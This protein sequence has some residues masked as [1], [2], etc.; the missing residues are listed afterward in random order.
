M[1]NFSHTQIFRV[2]IFELQN[3]CWQFFSLL[4]SLKSA[5]LNLRERR[6]FI[7]FSH[8]SFLQP[9]HKKLL[10]ENLQQQKFVRAK[11]ERQQQKD[12]S[13]SEKSTTLHRKPIQKEVQHFQKPLQQF[14]KKES[15]TKFWQQFFKIIENLVTLFSKFLESKIISKMSVK[16]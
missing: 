14:C 1:T 3:S 16:T 7:I 6:G 9:N 8:K 2:A 13:P 11:I 10:R 15:S 5:E 12:C 4:V